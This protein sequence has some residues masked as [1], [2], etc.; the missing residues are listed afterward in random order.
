MDIFIVALLV[1]L[2]QLSNAYLRYLPFSGLLSSAKRQHLFIGFALWTVLIW[3]AE[4]A[5]LDVFGL[6]IFIYKALFLFG[7]FPYFLLA[8]LVIPRQLPQHIFILGMR[9]VFY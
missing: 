5:V 7:W 2:I 8:I 6:R 3:L 9:K 4:A 1:S